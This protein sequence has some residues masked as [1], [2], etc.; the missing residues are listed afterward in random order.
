[1]PVLRYRFSFCFVRVAPCA[2]A[3]NQ[4]CQTEPVTWTSLVFD[5]CPFA[6]W[7]ILTAAVRIKESTVK[8]LLK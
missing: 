8:R 3:S 7:N 5:D 2:E 4:N 6:I 1:M